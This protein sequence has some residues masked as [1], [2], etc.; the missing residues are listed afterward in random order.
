MRI[1]FIDDDAVFS[2]T[3]SE[4][5]EEQNIQVDQAGCGESGH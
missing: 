1:L 5:L 3:L 4:M 2:N